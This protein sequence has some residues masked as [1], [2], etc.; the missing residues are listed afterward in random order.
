[1]KMEDTKKSPGNENGLIND[2]NEENARKETEDS[3][4]NLED[5][6]E[7]QNK[8][9]EE[10]L[11]GDERYK[12]PSCKQFYNQP[13]FLSCTHT[14][15][16]QCCEKF[17]EN[18]NHIQCPTCQQITDVSTINSLVDNYILIREMEEF[19]LKNGSIE[20]RA[21]TSNDIGVAHCSTCSSYLCAKCCQAHQYMKCFEQHHVRRL[22]QIPDDEQNSTRK[23]SLHS[24]NEIKYFCTTCSI[25]L[26]DQCLLSHPSPQ[27]DVHKNQF[28]Q[29]RSDFKENFE[30]I[31]QL[32]SNALTYLDHRL[33]S[34]QQIYEKTKTQIDSA[35]Q[36]YQQVLNQ[37]YVSNMIKMCVFIVDVVVE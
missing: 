20:C 29:I 33:T 7:E 27:H 5:D 25:P 3:L 2:E 34:L 13:K 16:F 18:K 6:D 12:C 1:M 15:C 32:R 35:H 19:A 37:V 17:L 28:E 11:S 4:F 9:H 8:Q 14:F 24:K 26:C 10:E 31:D 36:Q 23:C 22:S 21:C 30:Q